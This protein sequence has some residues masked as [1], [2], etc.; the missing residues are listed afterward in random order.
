MMKKLEHAVSRGG[1]VTLFKRLLD[2]PA[3]TEDTLV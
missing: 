1:K 2:A 3:A